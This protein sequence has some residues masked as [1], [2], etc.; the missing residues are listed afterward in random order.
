MDKK[1]LPLKDRN[2]LES[3]GY[4][5]REISDGASNGLIIDNFNVTPTEKFNAKQASLLIILPQGYP[6]VPPDMFYFTPELR[7]TSNNT[8]PDRADQL[9]NHFQIKWQQW[10]RHANASEWRIGIDGI[11]SYLQRVVTALKVA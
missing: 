8:F 4:Q 5:Y 3:K 6:D 1:I 11:H 7:F 2:Y 10:S 9:V